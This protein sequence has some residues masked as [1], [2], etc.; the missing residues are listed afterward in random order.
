MSKYICLCGCTFKKKKECELHIKLYEELETI[1]GF[2]R[3]KIFK[4]HWQA[5]FATW[6]FSYNWGRMFRF[7][8]GLMVYSV[9]MT[10]FKV[11]LSWLEGMLI[12]IGMGLYIE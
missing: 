10:H 5:R 2:P 7:I 12:G 1:E 11:N 3:H 8:G 6:F 9:L 4:Q